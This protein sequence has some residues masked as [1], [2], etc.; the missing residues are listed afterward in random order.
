MPLQIDHVTIAGSDLKQM[1]KAFS[2]LGLT[3]EYGGPHSNGTT[4]MA[5]LGFEDGSYIELISTLEPGQ[6]AS[7]WGEAI[8]AN[9]GPCAWAVGSHDVQAD[10]ERAASAGITVLGPQAMSRQRPDGK[11]VEWELAYLGDQEPGAL[12]PFIIQD[13]T[14]RSLRVKPTAG[15]A[16]NGLSGVAM[17]VLGVQ[18]LGT[19]TDVFRRA[20]GLEDSITHHDDTFGARL[21]HFPDTPVV[22]A[23]PTGENWLAARL[24][25]FGNSPCAYLIRTPDLQAATADFGL[26]GKTSWFGRQIAW[27]GPERL[28]GT[29]LGC[30]Q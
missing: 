5:L 3:P 27:F 16:E 26:D 18:D 15:L 20:F 10:A 14:P 13:R 6:R 19:A 21:A 7:S 24:K 28:L 9:A 2:D 23:T 30:T 17:V 11:L 8:A 22:L 29:R 12:L 1:Q 25:R 4:H